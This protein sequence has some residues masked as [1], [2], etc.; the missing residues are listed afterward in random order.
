MPTK[1]KSMLD[2]GSSSDDEVSVARPVASECT[3]RT[4]A[5][6]RKELQ[7]SGI[8]PKKKPRVSVLPPTTLLRAPSTTQKN[9]NR[10]A[11]SIPPQTSCGPPKTQKKLSG[12]RVVIS[13]SVETG[14]AKIFAAQLAKGG[15]IVMPHLPEDL[16]VDLIVVGAPGKVSGDITSAVAAGAG[17]VHPEWVCK[18]L[19]DKSDARYLWRGNYWADLVW[20][21]AAVLS[22]S[23][24]LTSSSVESQLSSKHLSSPQRAT[25]DDSDEQSPSFGNNNKGVINTIENIS[26]SST[27]ADSSYAIYEVGIKDASIDKLRQTLACQESGTVVG[28][29]HNSFLTAPLE[30]LAQQTTTR[31]DPKGFRRKAYLKAAATLRGLTFQVQSVHDVEGMQGFN[32]NGSSVEKVRELLENGSLQRLDEFKTDPVRAATAALKTVWGLGDARASELVSKGIH[33]VEQ[34]R[35]EVRRERAAVTA[36]TASAVTLVS[37]V[38]ERTLSVHEDLQLKIPR[39]QVDNGRMITS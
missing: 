4:Q 2:S 38:V 3:K 30:E 14:R 29:N 24:S 31:D 18:L 39:E 20:A 28:V 6:P 21:P 7:S 25:K 23:K 15:A 9:G 35:T 16:N 13:K 8:L 12:L 37:P 33:S 1:F 22:T 5:E 27:R 32:R 17:F 26:S 34:L 19:S 10:A 11:P 36:G